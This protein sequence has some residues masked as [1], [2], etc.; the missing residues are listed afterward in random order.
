MFSSGTCFETTKFLILFLCQ[1]LSIR[2]KRKAAYGRGQ[3]CFPEPALETEFD[4]FQH[5]SVF[6]PKVYPRLFFFWQYFQ[7]RVAFSNNDLQKSRTRGQQQKCMGTSTSSRYC[8]LGF[9]SCGPAFKLSGMRDLMKICVIHLL[10]AHSWENLYILHFRPAASLST[11][12]MKRY[13]V[14]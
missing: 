12:E 3:S 1:M 10:Y 2:R 14:T 13:D 9:S 11:S 6:P 5:S 7:S 4:S 8:V